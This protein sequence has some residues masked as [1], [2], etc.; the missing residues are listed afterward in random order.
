M[1]RNPYSL[2]FNLISDIFD[3][4]SILHAAAIV[5]NK[6][7]KEKRGMPREIQNIRYAIQISLTRQH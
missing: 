2:S 6:K 4:T 1:D 3:I 7:N 5:R